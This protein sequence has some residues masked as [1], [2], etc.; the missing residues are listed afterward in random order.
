MWWKAITRSP[1]LNSLHAFAARRHH[2]GGF[3]AENAR[4]REQVVLDLLQVGVADAASLHAHQHL[5]RADLGN[6]HT[7][8]FNASIPRVDRC[9]HLLLNQ[10]RQ[11]ARNSPKALDARVASRA[12][13][14][15]PGQI[16]GLHAALRATCLV[17]TRPLTS[18]KQVEV[19]RQVL[20]RHI[21]H[22]PDAIE[23]QST[24][25]RRRRNSDRL[26]LD[27]P[28]P[29]IGKPRLLGSRRRHPIDR[30]HCSP[31]GRPLRPQAPAL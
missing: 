12:S 2:A 16:H 28:R 14:I 5:S 17:L 24:A 21:T 25:L 22:H 11:S 10:N 29:A 8:H 6:R 3:V 23:W 18:R 4:R 30:Q 13:R 15:I 19:D 9:V 31:P 1:G 27:H 26:H 7:L 20:A